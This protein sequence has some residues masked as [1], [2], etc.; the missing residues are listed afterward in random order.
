M[1]VLGA[2]H[3]ELSSNTELVYN[4]QWQLFDLIIYDN[5][6]LMHKRT[7]LDIDDSQERLFWRTNLYHNK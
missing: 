1:A 5:W 3:T 6:N 4:H 7:Q 2:I